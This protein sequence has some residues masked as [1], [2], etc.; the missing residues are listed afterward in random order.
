MPRRK[1][2]EVKGS[3]CLYLPKDW[4]YRNKIYSKKDS[5]EKGLEIRREI[6]IEEIKDGTLVVSPASGKSIYLSQIE[7][8]IDDYLI[9]EDLQTYIIGCYVSGVDQ[10]V[11]SSEK[12]ISTMQRELVSN[13]LKN[14]FGFEIIKEEEQKIIIASIGESYAM[15]TLIERVLSTVNLMFSSILKLALE[16]PSSAKKEEA[17]AIIR[18]DDDIDKYRLLIERQT[19]RFLQSSVIAAKSGISL[20]EA[21][22]YTEIG[23]YTERIADHCV[24]LTDDI[25]E[26]EALREEI[27]QTMEDTKTLFDETVKIILDPNPKL[28]R[29]M[30]FL[31]KRKEIGEKWKKI[32]RNTETEGSVLLHFGRVLDYCTDMIEVVV[33]MKAFRKIKWVAETEV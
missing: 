24:I 5:E 33:D 22:Y 21:K 20:I 18:R 16:K 4:C 27:W 14:L 15:I 7:I 3:F 13:L 32:N 17:L 11:L 12:E 1:I 8:N 25:A 28:A 29:A 30:Q 2:Q 10:L 31:R 23:R 26:E 6:D 19:H 9:E